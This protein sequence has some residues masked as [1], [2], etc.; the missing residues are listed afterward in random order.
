MNK[1]LSLAIIIILLSV[2]AFQV[3]QLT[4]REWKL[5]HETYDH[6]GSYVLRASD[7]APMNINCEISDHI[8]VAGSCPAIGCTKIGEWCD[9]IT[10]TKSF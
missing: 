5:R 4:Q 10:Q 9:Y 8:L 6:T 1:E 3:G 2:L 7:T